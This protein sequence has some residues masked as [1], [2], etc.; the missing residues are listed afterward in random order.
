MHRNS[1]LQRNL[2]LFFYKEHIENVSYTLPKTLNI[3]MTL[4]VRLSLFL[5]SATPPELMK[6]YTVAVYVNGWS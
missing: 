2:N 4:S 3:G 6:I 1:Y 5:I